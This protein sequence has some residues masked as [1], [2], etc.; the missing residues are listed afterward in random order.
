MLHRQGL[1]IYDIIVW[2]K[3]VPMEKESSHS[4]GGTSTFITL[5]PHIYS[6]HKRIDNER[7]SGGGM[8]RLDQQEHT[9]LYKNEQNEREMT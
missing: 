4:V 2:R 5:F 7:K 6:I 9:P 8:H 3:K 1:S